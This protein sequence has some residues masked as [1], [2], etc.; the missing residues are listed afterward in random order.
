MGTK[1]S[2]KCL[3]LLKKLLN[4][5]L[6]LFYMLSKLISKAKQEKK[7]ASQEKDG[8]KQSTEPSQEDLITLETNYLTSRTLNLE[9]LSKYRVTSINTIYY[10]PNYL[11]E[12]DEKYMNKCIYSQPP[13]RWSQLK[14]AKRR[15]QRWGGEVTSN[16]LEN[17]EPL[18]PWLEKISELLCNEKITEKK[19]NH[20]LLNEYPPGIGIMPHTDGPLYHPYVCILSMGSHATFE[21]FKDYAAF[22]EENSLGRLIVEPRSLL[23]FTD[24]AYEKYL[25]SIQDKDI[26]FIEVSYSVDK[27]NNQIK[28]NHSN[29]DNL[30]LT[31]FYQELKSQIQSEIDSESEKEL[32]KSWSLKRTTRLSLTIRYVPCNL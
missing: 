26:D 10:I 6:H 8:S 13:E 4:C 25:H 24:D 19:T 16:G 28:I 22:K 29:V 14:Y 18:A 27:S 23:I 5:E 31:K 30:H 2:L 9:D 20:V 12:D 17:T 1:L 15:L 7:Q 11:T 21:F 3:F 32:T